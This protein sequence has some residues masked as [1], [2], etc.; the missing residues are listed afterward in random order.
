M[1]LPLATVR[2]EAGTVTTVA[3]APGQSGAVDG[4]GSAARFTSPR[5]LAFD[6]L[7]PALR[8]VERGQDEGLAELAFIDQVRHPLVV[9]VDAH[10]EAGRDR[11]RECF[12]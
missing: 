8:V 3:G 9:R 11:L 4:T 5:G 12:F 1:S 2:K 10:A 7:G 6:A